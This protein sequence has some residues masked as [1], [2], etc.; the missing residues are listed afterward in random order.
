MHAPA[1]AR[2]PAGTVVQRFGRDLL[3]VLMHLLSNL[4]CRH[5]VGTPWTDDA[6]TL[7]AAI[8]GPAAREAGVAPCP[9]PSGE[10]AGVVA[11]LD[12]DHG[13]HEHVPL[14]VQ[15]VPV[16]VSIS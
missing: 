2:L 14:R 7:V 6:V 4:S 8:G 5:G 3:V 15:S 16:E 9:L 12:C 1:M 11:Q 13:L 10:S